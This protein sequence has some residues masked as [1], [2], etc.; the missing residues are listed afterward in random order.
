ML[1][2]KD[3]KDL[4]ILLKKYLMNRGWMILSTES[5]EKIHKNFMNFNK[6]EEWLQK[7]ARPRLVTYKV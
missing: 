2:S 1:N 5:I 3:T 7:K 6:E 4:F